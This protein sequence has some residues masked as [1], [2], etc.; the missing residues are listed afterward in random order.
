MH[1][2]LPMVSWWVR[3]WAVHVL[4][5]PFQ[6]FYS[7][8]PRTIKKFNTVCN[9]SPWCACWWLHLMPTLWSCP[10]SYLLSHALAKAAKLYDY[11]RLR[12]CENYFKFFQTLCILKSFQNYRSFV[13]YIPTIFSLS[14]LKLIS[15]INRIVK[16]SV[17]ENGRR[18]LNNCFFLKQP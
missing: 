9:G 2:W 15:Q 12:I 3:Q 16:Q 1:S 14:D 8:Y 6:I 11:W 5:S 4:L 10:M 7:T 18:E 17:R 13:S